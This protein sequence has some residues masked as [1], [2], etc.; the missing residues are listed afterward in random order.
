MGGEAAFQRY[1]VG[2]REGEEDVDMESWTLAVVLFFRLRRAREDGKEDEQIPLP[3]YRTPRQ[4]R[5]YQRAS[6]PLLR[7]RSECETNEAGAD[8]LESTPLSVRSSI[9]SRRGIR[10]CLYIVGRQ[11]CSGKEREEGRTSAETDFEL[12]DLIDG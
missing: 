12:R 8:S 4:Q 7:P 2:V 9:D 11:W 3:H 1:G 10:G 6:C 5:M